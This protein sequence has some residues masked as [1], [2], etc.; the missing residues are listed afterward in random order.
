MGNLKNQKM[1]FLFSDDKPRTC[2]GCSL[3]VGIIIV[4]VLAGIEGV[5]LLCSGQEGALLSAIFSFLFMG[6][7]LWTLLA[8]ENNTAR[9]VNFWVWAVMY[10]IGIV[11]MAILTIMLTFGIGS[12]SGSGG[13]IFAWW[14]A[15]GLQLLFAYLILGVAWYWIEEGKDDADAGYS[16][17]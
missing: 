11:F 14:V 12:F 7:G 16:K 4:T 8:P 15:F 13:I 2:C 1:P 10:G 6:T 9:V 17:A 5:L 3:Q